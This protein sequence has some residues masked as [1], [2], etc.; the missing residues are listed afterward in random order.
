MV[1]SYNITHFWDITVNNSA[2]KNIYK[3]IEFL[4]QPQIFESLFLQPDGVEFW[5]NRDFKLRLTDITQFTV[6]N[7]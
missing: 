7:I 3:A 4:P 2:L 6:W 5:Y 1:W